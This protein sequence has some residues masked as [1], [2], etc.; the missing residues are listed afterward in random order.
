MEEKHLNKHIKLGIISLLLIGVLWFIWPFVVGFLA[1]VGA[2]R[3]Y[4]LWQ[5][6]SRR[7]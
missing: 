3:I 2:V 7:D 4:R 6:H 5:N 1:I